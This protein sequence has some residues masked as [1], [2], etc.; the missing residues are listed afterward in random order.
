MSSEILSSSMLRCKWKYDL[1]FTYMYISKFNPDTHLVMVQHHL[2]LVEVEPLGGL[3]GAEVVEAVPGG[4]AEGVELPLRVE[5]EGGGRL[6]VA[7]A[8]VVALPLAHDVHVAGVAGE[9]A[10]EETIY[11]VTS[12]VSDLGRVDSDLACSLILLGQ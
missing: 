2:E 10:I 8:R 9:A 11:R 3:S 4:E 7:H 5:E 1:Q 6:L 12:Q